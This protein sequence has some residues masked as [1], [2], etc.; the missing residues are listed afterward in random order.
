MTT[1]ALWRIGDSVLFRDDDRLWQ[2]GTVWSLRFY[3]SGGRHRLNLYIRAGALTYVRSSSS[4][5]R[6]EALPADGD[7]IA[8]VLRR[9]R[10]K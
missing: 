9:P 5:K 10:M 4:V 3:D 2:R 6:P 1:P 8:T 7:G